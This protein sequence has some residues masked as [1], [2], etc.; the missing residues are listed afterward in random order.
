MQLD[1]WNNL[2]NDF[3]T[4]T[5]KKHRREKAVNEAKLY[6]DRKSPSLVACLHTLAENYNPNLQPMMFEAP[7]KQTKTKKQELKKEPPRIVNSKYARG[8]VDLQTKNCSY[9][10]T[11]TELSDKLRST[12]QTNQLGFNT[13]RRSVGSSSA[14]RN[15]TRLNPNTN[16]FAHN[17]RSTSYEPKDENANI[18]SIGTNFKSPTSTSRQVTATFRTTPQF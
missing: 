15:N 12:K 14:G 7:I 17:S 2:S 8:E 9:I 1:R 10:E 16:K 13:K 6:F 18:L 3:Q 11:E 4:A 5:E